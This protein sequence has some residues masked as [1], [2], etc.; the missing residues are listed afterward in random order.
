MEDKKGFSLRQKKSSRRPAISGPRQLSSQSTTSTSQAP[1]RVNGLDEK[2]TNA[3]TERPSRPGEKTAD[4]IKRRYST[5]FA[6]L[7]DFNQADA[8][9]LPNGRLQAENPKLNLPVPGPAISVNVD[10]AALKDPHLDPEK[11]ATTVLAEASDQ[12]LREYQTNLRKLKNRASTDL[13]Q[14]VF[15]NRTQFIKIS[16]DAEKLNN[17]MRSLRCQLAEVSTSVSNLM[18]KANITES[19]PTPDDM[20]TRSRKQANR[21]SRADLE[22]LWNTQLH[23][24][25][26]QVEGSQK[27]LPAIPGRHIIS[28]QSR[29]LELDAATWRVKKRA[30]IILLNDHLMV[31]TELKRRVDPSTM[32]DGEPEKK[33]STKLVAERC[34]PLQDIDILDLASMANMREKHEMANAINIRC[35]HESFTYRSDRSSISD[36]A[37]LLSDFRTASE[38]IRR[39]LRAN[40][41]TSAKG[42]EP[43]NYYAA[44]DPALAQKTDLL[45]SL[46]SRKN[47]PEI[48]IDVDGKQ[49]NLRWVEGQIDELDIEIALQHFEDA[50]RHVEKLRKLAQGLKGNAMAQE[51]IDAKIGG[52]ANKLADLVVQRLVDTHSFSTA[53]QTNIAWLVR[54]GFDDRARESFL[55]ARSEAITKRARQCIF[56]GDLR[57]YIF[58]VSFVYFTLMK[59]TVSIFQQCF[60]PLV[61]SAC[62]K[63]AKEHLDGFN[64]IL[65]R[66]LSSVQ[67]GSPTWNECMDQAKEHAMMVNE[68]GLDFKEL[69]RVPEEDS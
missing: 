30:H 36:K 47:R 55:Q 21:S 51:L 22:T 61:M 66:Q 33:P 4:L 34:W 3:N 54:L 23:G 39:T 50:V 13:Q 35:G 42:K 68:V 24:L 56:E 46:S 44:R 6:Q 69:V 27:Y 43:M 25:W 59:N 18:S 57:D 64:V 60:P 40:T 15:Q 28:E 12:Q 11:Y 53:T 62:V 48:L 20:A 32:T 58:Q 14:N 10:V 67:R 16:K 17:E 52:R 49:R 38:E 31:A 1:P 65:S 2:P 7:P 19:R 45:R 41:E 63:W 26:K 9:P 29:W 8:P 37:K 5:R